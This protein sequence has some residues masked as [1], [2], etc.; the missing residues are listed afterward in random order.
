MN[1]TWI[2]FVIVT[3][4]LIWKI[5]EY[6]R[7][8][9]RSLPFSIT[10]RVQYL[11]GPSKSREKVFDDV[12]DDI[13]LIVK[14]CSANSY[15]STKNATRL[16]N[17]WRRVKM[18]ETNFRDQVA[19]VIDKNHKFYLCVSTPENE[20]ENT[21]TMRFVVIHELAH[22]MSSSYGHNEEF[23]DNFLAL[24]NVAVKL[25]VYIPINYTKNPANYCGI[26]ISQSPC[27]LNLCT[28]L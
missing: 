24:L 20:D 3:V 8:H 17:N 6:D 26:T 1:V 21:N 25:G 9:R 2:V 13:N 16:E 5:Y 23:S 18:Y 19:Y 28:S 15:P 11:Q 7:K 27:V 10:K 22:M 12:M 4:W 14:W